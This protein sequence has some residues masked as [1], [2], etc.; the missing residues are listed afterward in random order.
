[1]RILI[2]G[3]AGFVGGHLVEALAGAHTLAGISRK[4]NQDIFTGELTDTARVDA[5][6]RAF[7]PEWLIHLAGYANTG[8]S[9]KEPEACWRDNLTATRSLWPTTSSISELII[10]TAAPFVVS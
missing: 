3:I 1:M 8:G 6:V 2:T 4:P 10:S 5:I 9:F 7:Q